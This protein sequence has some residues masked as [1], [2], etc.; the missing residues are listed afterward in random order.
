MHVQEGTNILYKVRISINDCMQFK[1]QK[2]S[3]KYVMFDTLY[4]GLK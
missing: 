1:N 3:K 2:I 4:F